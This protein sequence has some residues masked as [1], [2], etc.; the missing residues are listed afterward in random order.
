MLHDNCVIV[1][2]V[3]LMPRNLWL[4]CLGNTQLYCI[5]HVSYKNSLL[6]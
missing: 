2:N 4:C 1:K 3:K 6:L 5:F